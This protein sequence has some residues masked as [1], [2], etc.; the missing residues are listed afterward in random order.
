MLVNDYQLFIQNTQPRKTQPLS[1][2]KNENGNFSL[3]QK[4]QTTPLYKQQTTL[5]PINYISSKNYYANKFQLQQEKDDSLKKSVSLYKKTSKLKKLPSAYSTSFTTFHDLSKPKPA[6]IHP[7]FHTD[8]PFEQLKKEHEKHKMVTT[9]I[10]NDL[11]YQRT[12]A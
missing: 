7:S 5:L 8:T 4:Q 1:Q 9:Y 2:K 6:L 12:S 10:A 3:T 11:Y